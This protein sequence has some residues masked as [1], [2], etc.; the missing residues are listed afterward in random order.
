MKVRT[1]RDKEKKKVGIQIIAESCCEEETL[2]EDLLNKKPKIII[3]RKPFGMS[4]AIVIDEDKASPVSAIENSKG[5]RF[6]LKPFQ[7][8]HE[9]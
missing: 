2:I 7:E 6:H 8:Q 3:P 5:N 1:F 4:F 9:D